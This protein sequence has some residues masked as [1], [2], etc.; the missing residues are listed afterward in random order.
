MASKNV[1]AGEFP[2]QAVIDLGFEDGNQVGFMVGNR[3]I[4][5]TQL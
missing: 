1:H 3:D 2:D 4:E 5:E